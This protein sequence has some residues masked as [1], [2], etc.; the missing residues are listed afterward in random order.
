MP[1][2]HGDASRHVVIDR[3]PGV[4]LSF[5][6]VARLGD[7]LVCVYRETDSH[8]PAYQR[9]LWKTSDDLGRCWSAPRILQA[10]GCHCPRIVHLEAEGN[11]ELAVISDGGPYM[12]WSQDRGG[13]FGVHSAMGL[14]HS[15]PDRILPLDRTTFLTTAHVHRGRAPRP[16]CGQPPTEQMTYVSKNRG[17]NWEPLAVHA[18]DPCLALCEAS[19]CRLPDGRLLTLF[20]ENSGVCEPMYA[21]FSSDRGQTWSEPRPTPLVGH[22][23]TL[24]T[25]S[26]G[27]LLVTYRCVGPHL[28]TSAWLGG[29]DELCGDYQVHGLAPGTDTPRLDAE[30]LLAA[31]DEG[32]AAPVRYA[33]RPLTSPVSARAELVV[34]LHVEEA[35]DN[36]CC[37]C[38][39]G[40]WWSVTPGAVRPM[41]PGA[42]RIAIPAGEVELGFSYEPGRVRLRVNGRTR[43]RRAVPQDVTARP[44]IIGNRD[45]QKGNGGR[46]RLL[47]L[48]LRI[49]E[50]RYG[51]PDGRRYEWSWTPQDGLPDAWVRRNTLELADARGVWGGDMGYSGWCE[52]PDGS[53]FCAYH[54]AEA[55]DPAYDKT[56]SSYV[57]GTFFSPKDFGG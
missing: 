47:A 51:G 14:N 45:T 52:L 8:Y 11:C 56:R 13:S 53:F 35:Q 10:A 27:R 30:G 9:L 57:R 3:R 16:E 39:G 7:R 22:R 19:M 21:S 38:F 17:V 40:L 12:A 43:L 6:D 42:R 41:V 32:G 55:D 54:H 1:S 26:D 48:R 18:F 4:Y 37:V 33:L 46:W 20:R 31:N 36:A 25:T 2:I 28:S 34:R 49:D 24:G 29:L 44:V 23:P 50:P 15:M 5:P